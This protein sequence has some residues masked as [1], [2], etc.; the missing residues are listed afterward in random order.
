MA[1]RNVSYSGAANYT[2]SKGVVIG[3]TKHVALDLAPNVRVNAVCPGATLTTMVRSATTAEQREATSE[4]IPLQ[5]W[6]NPEDQAEGIHYLL[7]P[8]ASYVTGT[9]IEIDR[10]A[11]VAASPG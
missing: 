1:G 3:L 5:R 11:Q 8:A 7:S 2:A 6:A 4:A 10:G 9:V